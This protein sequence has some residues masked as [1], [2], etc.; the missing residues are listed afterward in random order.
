M[1]LKGRDFLT[2]L[3]FTPEEISYL[4]DLSAEL[5]EKKKNGGRNFFDAEFDDTYPDI[6]SF[7][8]KPDLE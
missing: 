6:P 7:L 4:L 8:K 5:K 3:D 1:T 2:L